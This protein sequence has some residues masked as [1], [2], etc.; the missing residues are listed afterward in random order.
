MST[1]VTGEA[2]VQ[3]SKFVLNKLG[4]TV[5]P[6]TDLFLVKNLFCYQTVGVFKCL[7]IINKI[8]GT[9]FDFIVNQT[10]Q[11]EIF[12][13]CT[14]PAASGKLVNVLPL[15]FKFD[16]SRV[17]ISK[18]NFL[19]ALREDEDIFFK[20]PVKTF[21]ASMENRSIIQQKFLGYPVGYSDVML[22]MDSEQ[23]IRMAD[24]TMKIIGVSEGYQEGL[25]R[26]D[27]KYLLSPEYIPHAY[28]VVQSP[29]YLKFAV[30]QNMKL[31]MKFQI[32]MHAEVMTKS[33]YFVDRFMIK[34]YTVKTVKKCSFMEDLGKTCPVSGLTILS[35]RYT[36]YSFL[37]K[38]FISCMN[39]CSSRNGSHTIC[40][41]WVRFIEL[42]WSLQH[43]VTIY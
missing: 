10:R 8:I 25:V 33:H 40:Y 41:M 21:A 30:D 3:V 7:H 28:S 11:C 18:N 39:F 32:P 5:G 12:V 1:S 26:V 16:D 27:L 24:T 20:E 37:C 31:D 34:F 17:K 14:T 2:R 23:N 22:D 36:S 4:V 35:V 13:R 43:T 9:D 38:Y 15:T 29:K 19:E 6:V 42:W